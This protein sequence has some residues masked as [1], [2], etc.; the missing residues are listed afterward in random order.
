MSAN[1]ITG[2]ANMKNI[3]EK[4]FEMDGIRIVI[5]VLSGLTALGMNFITIMMS[6]YIGDEIAALIVLFLLVLM[7]FTIFVHYI[8]K[9]KKIEKS[10]IMGLKTWIESTE[11]QRKYKGLIAFISEPHKAY[12]ISQ[13]T[14]AKWFEE[15][16]KKID[17][18]E[19]T[20]NAADILTIQGIGQTFKAVFHHLGGLEQC[21][22]LYTDRSHNNIDILN[23]FF[24]R[25]LN[26]SINIEFIKIDNPNDCKHIKEKVDN[27]YK[28]LPKGMQVSDIIA[29]ITAGN[30]PMTAGMI[31]ACLPIDRKI[32][33]VEQSEKAALIEIEVSP[34]FSGVDF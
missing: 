28:N 30:K 15:C 33:Y 11:L 31:I 6:K 4:M 20:K 29:D 8:Q 9:T 10:K 26:N 19:E 32:E 13:E 3:F 7:I 17:T 12:L 23:Y 16:K 14:K 25:V 1:F 18:F 27:I 21:W 22:L 34:K 2:G 24:K 5:I